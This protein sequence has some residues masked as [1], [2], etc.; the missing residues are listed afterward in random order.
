MIER[1]RVVFINCNKLGEFRTS[2]VKLFI[3]DGLKQ[4]RKQSLGDFRI[5]QVLQDLRKKS[6][7]A[8]PDRADV[9][10]GDTFPRLTVLSEDFTD[11]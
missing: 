11:E 7:R 4:L 6:V 5:R 10:A 1:G 3:H 2:K 8:F 9:G